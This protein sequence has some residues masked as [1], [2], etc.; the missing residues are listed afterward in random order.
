R[1]IWTI[2]SSSVLTLFAC[3]YS[4]IHA[5]IPSPKDS[6]HGIIRRQLGV[7]IMALIAPELIVTWAMRQW[8]SARHVTRHEDYTWTQ[9]HS[10]FVLMG[11]FML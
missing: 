6:P 9:T 1:T 7:M 10:F 3:I 5:N 8:L 4:A 11:G 2:V